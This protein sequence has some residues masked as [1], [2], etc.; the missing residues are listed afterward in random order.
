MTYNA[1]SNDKQLLSTWFQQ[2][3]SKIIESL[4]KLEHQYA[5]NQD[6]QFVLREWNRSASDAQALPTSR[7]SH[8]HGGGGKSAT[9]KGSLFEKAGVNFSEVFGKFSP[10]FARQIPGAQ[11]DPSFWASG[12]S[13]VIH[14]RSPHVPAIHMNTRMIVTN[15]TW[16]GGGADLTPIFPVEQDTLDFHQALADC[17]NRHNP[18]YYPKYKAWADSYFFLPHRNEPRGIGGIFYDNLNS[19]NFGADVNFTHDVGQTFIDIYEI[20]VKRNMSKTWTEE[21]R[22]YQ[23]MRRG[24]YVEFNLLYDRGTLF[25]LKTGGH[26]ESILMSLPPEVSWP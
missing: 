3:Q 11:H 2:L 12:V 17:C 22:A 5:Q 26:T 1:S 9:L 21:E 16:F 18:D 4:L 13:V 10:E 6:A 19:G 20:L 25:G 15:Q 14:P 23:L 7:E 24:R 8:E